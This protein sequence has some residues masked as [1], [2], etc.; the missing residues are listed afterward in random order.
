[1]NWPGKAS[2]EMRNKVD[3]AVSYIV[4]TRNLHNWGFEYDED[5]ESVEV[6]ELFKLFLDPRFVDPSDHTPPYREVQQWYCDYLACLYHYV[7]RYFQERIPRFASRNVEFVFSVPTTWKDPGM[8]AD[9][10]RLIRSAGYGK[11]ANQRVVISLTEAEAAAVYVYRWVA[12][13][14]LSETL[15]DLEIIL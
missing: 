6:N 11:K 5:D 1:M 15:A 3:T 2:Y 12:P 8:M 9:I 7:M 10:E 14:I 4:E 13:L